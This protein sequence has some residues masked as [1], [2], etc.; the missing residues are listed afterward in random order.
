MAHK[1]IGQDVC[2]ANCGVLRPQ[3]KPTALLGFVSLGILAHLGPYP[4]PQIVAALLVI[5]AGLIHTASRG[6]THAPPPKP[7][8]VSP[9]SPF[10]DPSQLIDFGK[11]TS[12]PPNF[13]FT[14]SRSFQPTI[15]VFLYFIFLYVLHWFGVV[16]CFVSNGF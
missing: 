1:M 14:K 4:S 12:P 7:R 2:S 10:H 13:L 16:V 15:R 6:H 11:G 9:R 3:H 8:G 5:V